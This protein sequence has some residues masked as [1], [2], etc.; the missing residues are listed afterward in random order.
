MER[1]NWKEKYK[2]SKKRERGRADGRGTRS[3]CSKACNAEAVNGAIS[4]VISAS[5][6]LKVGQESATARKLLLFAAG[7]VEWLFRKLAA[8]L[9]ATGQARSVSRE[10][11]DRAGEGG[12]DPQIINEG[13][14]EQSFATG[15]RVHPTLDG[16]F[17][18]SRDE[19]P[20]YTRRAT[21]PII[22]ATRVQTCCHVL[23]MGD[24][25]KTGFSV[26]K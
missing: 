3:I 12:V 1:K 18:A 24:T 25:R 2:R 4:R 13:P 6:L 17:D 7:R 26:E 8:K 15:W 19:C 14:A 23:R 20:R 22:L 10:A 16:K 9:E 5:R 11:D 21:P